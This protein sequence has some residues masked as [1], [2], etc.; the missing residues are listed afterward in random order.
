MT[1]KWMQDSE[2]PFASSFILQ[3]FKNSRKASVSQI[4]FL[5]YIKL[6]TETE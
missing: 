1:C 2:H 6:K 4:D 3:K 5:M